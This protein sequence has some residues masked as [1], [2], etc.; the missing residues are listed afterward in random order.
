MASDFLRKK[1]QE[2]RKRIDKSVGS[3]YY[4][5]SE[6]TPQKQETSTPKKQIDPQ[7]LKQNYK[8]FHAMSPVEQMKV[9]SS[10]RSEKTIPIT[11]RINKEKRDLEAEREERRYT[12]P[13]PQLP[14][15]QFEID[16]NIPISEHTAFDTK[17]QIQNKKYN[18]QTE[19]LRKNLES[20]QELP[21]FYRVVEQGKQRATQMAK[22][23]SVGTRYYEEAAKYAA[24]PEY[25]DLLAISNTI[26]ELSTSRLSKMTDTEKNVL[27]YY[28]GTGDTGSAKKYYE[29]VLER[30]L[31]KRHQIA[32]NQG[33]EELA[34]KNKIVGVLGNIVTSPGQVAGVFEAFRQNIENLIT[35][36]DKPVD[37][38][39]PA[40]SAAH[41]GNSTA[42]G[43]T[44]DMNAFERLLVQ[45]GLSIWAGWFPS[46]H[47]Q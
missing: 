31:N 4:G 47:V 26:P 46:A 32:F 14:T 43:I 1:A 20:V 25:S 44:R 18:L 8:S 36:Q 16:Q 22:E 24:S 33:V 10:Q 38:Y 5:G 7:N 30:E 15:D 6:Y 45:T 39:S 27:L 41:F 17:G 29:D 3:H 40:M 34:N 37:A 2:S 21:D 13:T 35:G 42:Q 11:E 23:P 9:I 19:A 12:R 28:V